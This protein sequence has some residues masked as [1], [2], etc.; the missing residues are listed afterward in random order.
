MPC[1]DAN[2]APLEMAALF[3]LYHRARFAPASAMASATENPIP[4]EAPVIQTNRPF[5]ESCS[6]TFSGVA[7][8]GLGARGAAHSSMDIDILVRVREKIN[9]AMSSSD[10]FD[11]RLGNM[12]DSMKS[13][14]IYSAGPKLNT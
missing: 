10:D 2:S 12:P 3:V 14:H 7:G 9:E 5:I 11:T 13:V 1:V 8:T 6:K 4:S